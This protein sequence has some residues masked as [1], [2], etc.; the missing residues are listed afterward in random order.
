[1]V[2]SGLPIRNGRQH[3]GEIATMSLKLMSISKDFEIAHMPGVPLY[4]RVGIH[5]GMCSL[6][7]HCHTYLQF[8]HIKV[9]EDRGRF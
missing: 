9:K 7:G 1:M 8:P 2:V 5:S 6:H 3:A 4:L